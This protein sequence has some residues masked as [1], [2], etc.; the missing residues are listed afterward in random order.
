MVTKNESQWFQPKTDPVGPKLHRITLK[1]FC[2]DHSTYINVLQYYIHCCEGLCS[3]NGQ[4]SVLAVFV[5]EMSRRISNSENGKK[6]C[7]FSKGQTRRGNPEVDMWP[8]AHP[9]TLLER[10]EWP[11]RHL[12]S[13]CVCHAHDY[14]AHCM[15]TTT[16]SNEYNIGAR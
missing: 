9:E 13:G 11:E 7:R 12:N 3:C 2:R 8:V 4:R 1:K 6:R 15:S 5:T 10:P 14:L 16:H